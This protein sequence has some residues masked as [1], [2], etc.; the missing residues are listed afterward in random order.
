MQATAVWAVLRLT[1][2]LEDTQAL[3]F[4][5]FLRCLC[6]TM[7][8]EFH[9]DGF[10]VAPSLDNPNHRCGRPVIPRTNWWCDVHHPDC[11]PTKEQPAAVQGRTIRITIE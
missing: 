7:P 4:R 2:V 6:V 10:C 5:N 1:Q 8:N 11:K 3:I 9:P